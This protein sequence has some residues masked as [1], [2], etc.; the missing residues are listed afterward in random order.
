VLGGFAEV[1]PDR[2]IVLADGAELADEIDP[3]RARVAL[4]P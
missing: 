2:T 4:R 1:L 3:D